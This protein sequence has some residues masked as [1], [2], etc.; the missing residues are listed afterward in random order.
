MVRSADYK[1]KVPPCVHAVGTF[2]KRC[3]ADVTK[4]D[5][6]LWGGGAD[7][8]YT[9]IYLTKY[10]L[11]VIACNMNYTSLNSFQMAVKKL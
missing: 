10:R 7:Q 8:L 11:T 5:L 3:I 9:M 4:G 1:K 6:D 2:I